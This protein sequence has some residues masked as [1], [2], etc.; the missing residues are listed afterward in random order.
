MTHS[1]FHVHR[2]DDIV[3]LYFPI[4]RPDILAEVFQ[5]R[6]RSFMLHGCTRNE[7]R[8]FPALD[9]IGQQNSVFTPDRAGIEHTRFDVHMSSSNC[10]SGCVQVSKTT[11]GLKQ[12]MLERCKPQ[13]LH[14]ANQCRTIAYEAQLK[15]VVLWRIE[16]R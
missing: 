16:D 5:Q 2:S 9:Q 1:K 8:Q 15:T 13:F 7:Q 11:I 6:K 14:S 10:E 4:S 3:R 12:I